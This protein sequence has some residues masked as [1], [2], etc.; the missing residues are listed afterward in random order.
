MKRLIIVF[1]IAAFIGCIFAL[2]SCTTEEGLK[3]RIQVLKEQRDTLSSEVLTLESTKNNLVTSITE[4]KRD[5]SVLKAYADG[6]TVLYLVKF[7]LKQSHV[8]LDIG[9]H[10]KDA[11][12]AVEFEWPVSKTFY[13]KVNVGDNVLEEF[14]GGSFL[15]EGSIG[16]WKITVQDKRTS[17]L[18]NEQTAKSGY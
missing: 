8:S 4:L 3:D 10:I 18:S 12:N 16:N 9:K 15:V 5:E 6:E 7:K 17:T 2:L 14:R 13:D 11:A 1:C